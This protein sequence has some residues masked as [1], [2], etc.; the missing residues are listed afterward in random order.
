MRVLAG[1]LGLG[2]ALLLAAGCGG[3]GQVGFGSGASSRPAPT[4]LPPSTG[5][6]P[7]GA[8]QVPAARVDASGLPNGWPTTVWTTDGGR[9]VGLF[10]R[11]GGC[12]T[13][14]ANLA[15]QEARRVVIRLAQTTTGN[16]P[17]SQ[18]LSFPPLTVRLD[19]PLGGRTVALVVPRASHG[20][21]PNK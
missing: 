16:G 2:V 21:P 7:G 19:A 18:V 6:P 20:P 14:S 1:L 5:V 11:A 9:V 12:T 4:Q 8:T 10:G 15:S 17:C 3:S 13:V